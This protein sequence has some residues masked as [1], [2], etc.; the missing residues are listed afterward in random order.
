[1]L[2]RRIIGL[3]FA[4]MATT[5][6]VGAVAA[7]SMKRRIVPTTESDSD[8]I[9]LA[10]IFGPLAYK[11]TAKQFRGGTLECWYGGGVLDLREAV[12]APEG[13][14]LRVRA[15]FGGGQI[16]VPAD[17]KVVTTVAGLGGLTDTRPNPES[18]DDAP[19]LTISG[20]VFAGGFAVTSELAEGEAE[21]LDE[22]H[23]ALDPEPEAALTV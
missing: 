3:A 11:S 8:E 2:I 7:L 16:L 23:K 12:L 21:W 1:M 13:A 5:M 15:V 22:M 4:G 20:M 6:V 14:E 9:V 18:A 10:S 19:R 17:W